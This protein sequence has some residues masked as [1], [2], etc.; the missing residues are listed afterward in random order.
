MKFSYEFFFKRKKIDPRSFFE[1]IYT[2]EDAVSKLEDNDIV[3]HDMEEILAIVGEN[4]S[5][6]LDESRKNQNASSL[7]S[8]N[9][10]KSRTKRST[11]RQPR[12][13]KKNSATKP[14]GK[15]KS[16]EAKDE[17][18]ASYFKTWKVPYVEPE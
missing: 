7:S 3:N 12:A 6:R 15:D 1:G 8:S 10:S 13:K 11:R 9:S 16:K 14:S 17:E 18:D 5:V 2:V 4:N